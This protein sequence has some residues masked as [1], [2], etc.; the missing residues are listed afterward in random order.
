MRHVG[1]TLQPALEETHPS[2]SP[3]GLRCLHEL[4]VRGTATVGEVALAIGVAPSTA[5]RTADRLVRAGLV[6][7][8]A[9]E[10]DRRRVSL[11]LTAAGRTT[12]SEVSRVRTAALAASV[13]LMDE[14]DRAALLRGTQAFA[15]AHAAAAQDAVP[16]AE[17]RARASVVGRLRQRLS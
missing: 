8:C 12:L 3:P 15:A 7:R 17:G 10:E 14:D 4:D 11:S 2:L 13:V 9:G 16:A 5:S 6:E 1:A